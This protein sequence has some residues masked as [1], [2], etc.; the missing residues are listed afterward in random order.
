[1][2]IDSESLLNSSH[3]GFCVCHVVVQLATRHDP[4]PTAKQ[5]MEKNVTCSEPPCWAHG[6]V[7]S[8]GQAFF[9]LF[10]KASSEPAYR[11]L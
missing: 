8:R 2:L 5:L 10:P 3:C 1:M 9:V 6:A 11:N 7:S 4:S